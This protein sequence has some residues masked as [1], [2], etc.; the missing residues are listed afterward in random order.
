M[1]EGLPPNNAAYAMRLRCDEADARAVADL[2]VEFFDSG[3]CAASAFEI[4]EPGAQGQKAWL[5]EAYFGDEPDHEV[6]E[7]VVTAAGGAALAGQVEYY[8]LA[9][10]DWVANS[11]AGLAPVRVG[12]FVVHGAHDRQKLRENDI[13]I[14]IEAALA[15]G[16]GHH[17]TTRGC[18]T[19]LDRVL[20]RS[21]PQRILDIG[22]GT[23]VLAI[24]AARR[25][26]M[27]VSA[28]DIDPIAVDIAKGNA[29]LN[30]VG[31]Y[32]GPLVA[33]GVERAELQA[34][35]PYDL[36]FANILA[37]PLRKLAP[38]VARVVGSNGMVILSG[39]QMS[40]VRGVL[41]SWRAQ[42]FE[43]VERISIEGWASLLLRRGGA[44]P[45]AILSAR[46]ARRVRPDT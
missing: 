15:F 25:L 7:S 10:R 45:R 9:Q 11:L 38:S 41:A 16:T 20:K 42:R 17:G 6:V 24:A 33:R 37:G 26:H 34:L 19:L 35:S 32:V 39:L 1:I 2:L 4:D 31:Q 21:R 14:E 5:V 13:G 18:L 40:D 3:D 43:L 8:A 30:G 23:G 27:S 46:P 36:V 29:R 44:A 22:C 28:S 12:R